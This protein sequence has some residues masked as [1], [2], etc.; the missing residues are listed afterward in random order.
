MTGTILPG[1]PHFPEGGT[2]AERLVYFHQLSAVAA[3]GWVLGS[4]VRGGVEAVARWT[5]V[6][7]HQWAVNAA[8]LQ[9]E[10]FRRLR[11]T[12]PVT[13]SAAMGIAS[14]PANEYA[15]TL[16]EMHA[17]LAGPKH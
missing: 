4:V 10:T 15:V 5:D 6:E 14:G 9:I 16:N 2:A 13:E 7:C 3:H 8:N 1:G 17:Q 12:D 11:E